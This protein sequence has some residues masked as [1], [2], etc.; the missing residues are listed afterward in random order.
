MKS[1]IYRVETA[2]AGTVVVLVS[3]VHIAAWRNC[4][5]YDQESLQSTKYNK[6]LQS[7]SNA[8]PAYCWIAYFFLQKC[9]CQELEHSQR[10]KNHG[11]DT[12]VVGYGW[13][14]A[15]KV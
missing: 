7:L 6:S 2:N 14:F 13:K 12:W 15:G 10:E 9:P 3:S 5:L 8:Q 11:T 4:T 1:Y